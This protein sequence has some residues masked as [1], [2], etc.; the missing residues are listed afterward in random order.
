MINQTSP[1]KSL[2]LGL[3]PLLPA[4]KE[5]NTSVQR[6]L[7]Y[8]MMT[9]LIMKMK[10]IKQLL[11]ITLLYLSYGAAGQNYDNLIFDR[12]N[13]D[14][15]LIN[16]QI[17]N[18][19]QDSYGN[20]WICTANGI[21]IYDGVQIKNLNRHHLNGGFTFVWDVQDDLQGHVLISTGNGIVVYDQKMETFKHYPLLGTHPQGLFAITQN[22]S[23][24]KSG[25]VWLGTSNGLCRMEARED[26]LIY[27]HYLARNSQGANQELLGNIYYISD[28]IDGNIWAAGQNSL[29]VKAA[30]TNEFKA[31]ANRP[32]GRINGLFLNQRNEFLIYGQNG[33]FHASQ[34]YAPGL[35]EFSAYDRIKDENG[36]PFEEISIVNQDNQGNYWIRHHENQLTVAF[37]HQHQWQTQ[38]INSNKDDN[39]AVSDTF[40]SSILVDQEGV[41]WIGTYRY[42]VNKCYLNKNKFENLHPVANPNDRGIIGRN[43]FCLL[44]EDDELWFIPR[45]G[46]IHIL[47]TSTKAIHR[48]PEGL[49]PQSAWNFT[50]IYK[51]GN[52][53]YVTAEWTQ[54]GLFEITLPSDYL[55]NKN[56]A[57]FT[58]KSYFKPEDGPFNQSRGFDMHRDKAGRL[59]YACQAGLFRLSTSDKGKLTFE[60][61]MTPDGTSFGPINYM[62]EDQKS[63]LWLSIENG[64]GYYNPD[65][66]VLNKWNRD[67]ID[68][69]AR[70]GTVNAMYQTENELWIGH[71]TTGLYKLDK[72]KREFVDKIGIPDGLPSEDIR[73]VVADASGKIWL[74]TGQ[75]LVRL[76]PDTKEMTHY[77]KEDGLPTLELITGAVAKLEDG[78]AFGTTEGLTIVH[79]REL[80]DKEPFHPSVYLTYLSVNDSLVSPASDGLLNESISVTTSIT[81]DHFENNLSVGFAANSFAVP[82][83]LLFRY[84]LSDLDNYWKYTDVKN[85]HANYTNLSPGT[86]TLEIQVS[87]ID[88]V[89]SENIKSLSLEVLTPW[90]NSWW[91]RLIYISLTVL[92][93][94]RVFRWR[95][96]AAKAEQ[97]FLKQKIEEATAE[98]KAQNMELQAE[99]KNLES[100]I[101]DTN[102]VIQEAVE[103][104]NFKARIDASNK[105][106][107]WKSL[108][109]SINNLFDTVMVP[110]NSINTIVNGLAQGDMTLRYTEDAKGDVLQLKNNLN[111]ALDN[112]SSLLQDIT[113]QV[114]VIGTSSKE[115]LSTSEEMNTSTS[116]IASAISQMSAGAQNQL[117]KA[118]E[119]SSLVEGVLSF[120]REVGNQAETINGTANAGVNQSK[121][122]ISLVDTAGSNM[123]NLLEISKRTETSIGLLTQRS[124]E[125]TRFLSIMQEVAS[126]TN[127]LALNAAIEAAQAGESGRGFA[128]VA[129]EIRKLAEES[130]KSTKEIEILINDIQKDTHD[131]VEMIGQ[132]NKSVVQGEEATNF[133]ATAFKDI[134]TSYT[135]TYELSERIVD[136]TKQ[137]SNQISEI[138]NIM[139]SV[140]VIA[141]Q[142][143]AGTEEISSSASELSTGM[144]TYT[145]KSKNVTAIVDDLISKV[146][147]FKLNPSSANE[148]SQ[149]T[150][151]ALEK[152]ITIDDN[153][154]IE[155]DRLSYISYLKGA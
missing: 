26:T 17:R 52:R 145:E 149:I 147:R 73:S 112:L 126:Q 4:L 13:L 44:A 43:V 141:E 134:S 129:E 64:L 62:L 138:V 139:E 55:T 118:E 53:L 5:R 39:S 128:V 151:P 103:C 88:G 106:G 108:S 18:I 148:T 136:A 91:F 143:A 93:I 92:I 114:E 66:Q 20:I 104:G 84:R 48:L 117:M 45:L 22:L 79:P 137:Q 16:N 153:S 75:G 34:S 122:G 49:L 142:T 135:N 31:V 35:F 95:E 41:V 10:K 77:D 102:Y 76:D 123:K 86:Y 59:W 83:D 72:I 7:R 28:D 124:N 94:Y 65:T 19:A 60:E 71:G 21:S 155:V 132:M 15:G 70:G 61:E 96:K 46:P 109:Q 9:K 30:N 120:A 51:E 146:N 85:A 56:K 113:R 115:M 119:S 99:Q 12:I 130:K 154:D 87:N 78:I 29:Y 50:S 2:A 152:P 42:G 69:F 58:T 23:I 8:G 140:V 32:E 107:K 101:E 144:I 125:I 111:N 37:Y 25:N 36:K 24:D 57:A 67:N 81:L 97:A 47:N 80:T 3:P 82:G 14:G 98:V 89:W 6:G 131:T 38:K 68:G 1:C 54:T 121:N 74:G 100:T 27:H 40:A 150:A 116:E 90:W 33:I 127:L 105:T 11:T 110:F 133:S 63:G